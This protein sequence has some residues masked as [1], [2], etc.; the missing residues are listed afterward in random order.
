MWTP[1]NLFLQKKYIWINFGPPPQFFFGPP[2]NKF[3]LGPPKTKQNK[4]WLWCFY[5]HRLIDSVSPL[6]GIFNLKFSKLRSHTL[7]SPPKVL[8]KLAAWLFPFSWLNEDYLSY[9]TEYAIAYLFFLEVQHLKKN[10]S[11]T[12]RGECNFWVCYFSQPQCGKWDFIR[13]KVL[14]TAFLLYKISPNG[15]KILI[16]ANVN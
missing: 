12:S 5:P 15:K 3:F 13:S 14:T 1:S 6:C 8:W 7:Y 10:I 16:A 11:L 4:K 9:W 2:Q